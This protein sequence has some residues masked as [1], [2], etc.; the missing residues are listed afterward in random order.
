MRRLPQ[1]PVSG[2][3]GVT[4]RGLRA[5]SD[6]VASDLPSGIH[7]QRPVWTRLLFWTGLGLLLVLLAMTVALS[8]GGA[9]ISPRLV[10]RILW[11]RCLAPQALASLEPSAGILLEIRLP[12]V[13]VG[14]SVGAS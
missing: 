13:L 2:G 6:S 12:R 7:N 10:A 11:L 1:G 14:A 9:A 4:G 5:V 8:A 3:D